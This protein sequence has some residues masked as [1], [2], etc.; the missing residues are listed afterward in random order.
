MYLLV[1]ITDAALPDKL[2]DTVHSESHIAVAESGGACPT[3]PWTASM[4]P[5]PRTNSASQDLALPVRAEKH[6]DPDEESKHHS[7]G[8][9]SEW[10]MTS[11]T[12]ERGRREDDFDMKIS[13]APT[14]STDYSDPPLS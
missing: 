2:A 10:P 11:D 9:I 4:Q 5:L 13:V 3:R 1:V 8:T 7:P 12:V 6:G 14:R